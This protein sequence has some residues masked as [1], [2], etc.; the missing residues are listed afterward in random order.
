SSARTWP[1]G[2]ASSMRSRGSRL[3]ISVSPSATQLTGLRRGLSMQLPFGTGG[4]GDGLVRSPT[5]RPDQSLIDGSGAAGERIEMTARCL[6]RLP[7]LDLALH[8]PPP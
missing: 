3:R 8:I 7:P 6:D 1:F 5:E 2:S 4:A